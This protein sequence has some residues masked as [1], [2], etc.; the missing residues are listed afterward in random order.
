MVVQSRIRTQ[1]IIALLKRLERLERRTRGELSS[2]SRR[3]LHGHAVQR[4]QPEHQVEAMDAHNFS[5]RK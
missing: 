3:L 1:P 2:S 5:M 4:T